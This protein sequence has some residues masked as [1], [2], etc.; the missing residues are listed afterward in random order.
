M[1]TYDEIKKRE[2][3]I[4]EAERL[5]KDK[6]KKLKEDLLE[7]VKAAFAW[8]IENLGYNS[9]CLNNIIRVE[10]FS[11]SHIRVEY[12]CYSRYKLKDTFLIDIKEVC[13][14]E[15][16]RSKKLEEYKKW[17]EK[18]DKKQAKREEKRLL[19]EKEEYERLKKKF[20]GGNV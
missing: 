4:I 1:L 11:G 12:F 6:N 9:K 10:D 14:D 13:F 15:E 16:W 17:K 18:E 3:E 2:K 5:Y 7:N 8:G 20:E 19:K